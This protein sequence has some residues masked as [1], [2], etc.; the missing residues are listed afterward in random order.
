MMCILNYNQIW[1]VTIMV[2]RVVGMVLPKKEKVGKKKTKNNLNK[3]Q[4]YRGLV[5]QGMNDN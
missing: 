4:G 3:G 1:I 5:D 2:V